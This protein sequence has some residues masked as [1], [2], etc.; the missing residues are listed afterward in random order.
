MIDKE[1]QLLSEE[2]QDCLRDIR[3]TIDFTTT[4]TSVKKV[5][6]SKADRVFLGGNKAEFHSG[7]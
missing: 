7:H 3:Y 2:E 5:Q 1:L 4:V 6:S